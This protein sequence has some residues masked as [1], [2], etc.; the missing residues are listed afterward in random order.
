MGDEEHGLAIPLPEVG[1]HLLHDLAGQGIQRAEGFVHQQHLRVVRQRSSD[2]HPLFHATGQRL[3]IC[4]GEAVQLHQ[5]DQ[6]ARLMLSLGL[7]GPLNLET[8]LDVAPNREPRVERIGLEHHA[9]IGSGRIGRLA[10]HEH[11]AFGRRDQTGGNAQQRRLAAPGW[12][13]D[14]GELAVRHRQ[15]DLL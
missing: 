8:E 9:S 1:Q 6:F 4:L 10:I 3:R 5:A 2:R 15:R 14:A 13:N 7:G 11:I 12:A